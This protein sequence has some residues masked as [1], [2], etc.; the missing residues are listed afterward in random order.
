MI[1]SPPNVT[2]RLV[3]RWQS[4]LE[5]KSELVT[6]CHFWYSAVRTLLSCLP[7]T[8]LTPPSS[9][10]MKKFRHPRDGACKGAARII[11]LAFVVFAT[12]LSPANLSGANPNP[13]RSPTPTATPIATP[14]PGCQSISSAAIASPGNYYKVGDILDPFSGNL[15]GLA[16][17]YGFRL[18]VALVASPGP[19][20]VNGGCVTAVTIIPG[21]GYSAPPSNPIRF[22]G[23]ASGTGFTANCTF[24]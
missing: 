12:A 16:D 14:T 8:L 24:N 4:A 2:M 17:N 9:Y 3:G 7:T 1:I 13:P 6:S 21:I 23:S 22:G 5:V 19:T 11:V 15:C 18:Q 10:A 20:C